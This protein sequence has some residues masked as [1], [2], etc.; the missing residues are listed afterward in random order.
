MKWSLIKVADIFFG[1]DSASVPSPKIVRHSSVSGR[2][3]CMKAALEVML[4]L[5]R[6]ALYLQQP[7]DTPGT[8]EVL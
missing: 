1:A 7:C 8:F 3:P 4:R 2:I 5:V 6:F